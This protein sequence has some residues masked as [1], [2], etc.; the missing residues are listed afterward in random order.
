MSEPNYNAMTDDEF[1]LILNEIIDRQ[2]SS[3]WASKYP[4]I[5]DILKEELN[6]DVLTQW[7]NQNPHKAFKENNA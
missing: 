4:E 2:T 7:V 1:D 5:Y 3:T 6:N